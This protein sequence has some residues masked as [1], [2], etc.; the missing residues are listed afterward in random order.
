MNRV[1]RLFAPIRVRITLAAVLVVAAILAAAGFALVELQRR[2]LTGGVDDSVRL[3]A[4]DVAT[5]IAQGRL[6]GS[7]AIADDEVALVQVIDPAGTIVAASPNITGRSPVVD[8]RPPAGESV[9]EQVEPLPIDDEPFRVVVRTLRA[10]DGDYTIIVAGSL[11]DVVENIAI[12]VG[13]LRVG[14]P[15]VVFVAGA[16]VWWLVGRALAPVEAIRTSVEV[17]TADR[18]DHRVP[19]PSTGDE[20]ARLARTMNAMLGRIEAAYERQ[21]QFVADAAHE[22]RSPLAALR[23]EL[24][25][26][27]AHGESGSAERDRRLLED[28]LRMQRLADDLLALARDSATRERRRALVDLD[29]VVLAEVRR[30]T[31]RDGMM[32]DASAVSAAAVSGDPDQLARAVRNLLENALRHAGTRVLLALSEGHAGVTLTIA[33]DGPGIPPADREHIFERFTRLDE[34]RVRGTG[35]AGLGLA[36][37]RRI[38]EEHGGT[39]AIDPAYAVGARFVV[40]LPPSAP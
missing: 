27:L 9:I 20:I 17:L 25:V 33:D 10:P 16:G 29:D 36:I 26:D 32:I 34:S 19:E 21:E 14:I 31:P 6:E 13:F 18:L 24:E 23:A 8:F 3:R 5:L 12:L 30:A 28:I 35:G 11:D 2:A 37:T 1:R 7:I 40:T 4:D 39:V 15:I 22:L 38:I